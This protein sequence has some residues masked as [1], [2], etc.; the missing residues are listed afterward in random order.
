M[1]F[2]LVLLVTVCDFAA[3]NGFAQRFHSTQWTREDGLPSNT[4]ADIAQTPDGFLWV[5]TAEGLA[6]YDGA[7]FKLFNRRTLPILESDII[8]KLD[9]D[10]AG[11]LWV[12]TLTGGVYYKDANGWHRVAA[13]VDEEW[14]VI[15]LALGA[16]GDVWAGTNIGMA[17]IRPSPKGYVF[18]ADI[19]DRGQPVT[20]LG[21]SAGDSVSYIRRGTKGV[22]EYAAGLAAARDSAMPDAKR[23]SRLWQTRGGIA[24]FDWGSGVHLI[25]RRAPPR[26]IA[27]EKIPD[28]ADVMVDASGTVWLATL[29][30]GLIAVMP[31]GES[32]AMAQRFERLDGVVRDVFQARDGSIWIGTD[33]QG[34]I[35]LRQPEVE[36]FELADG[37]PLGYV[38][39]VAESPDGRIHIATTHGVA[40]YSSV[41][42]AFVWSGKPNL[43][44]EGL[45]FGM[46]A[47]RG[48][49]VSQPSLRLVDV[50]SGEAI[51]I[52]RG[53]LPPNRNILALQT[54][55]DGDVFAATTHGVM[56]IRDGRVHALDPAEVGPMSIALFE[57]APGEIWVGGVDSLRLIERGRLVDHPYAN[58]LRGKWVSGFAHAADAGFWIATYG[59]GA[60]LARGGRTKH[61]HEVIGFPKNN[62]NAMIR[63]RGGFLW[64]LTNSG[65][66]R[67]REEALTARE[68]GDATPVPAKAYGRTHGL[69][70]EET[71]GGQ[72]PAA[73]LAGDG[74][75]WFAT[76]GGVARIGPQAQTAVRAAPRVH[77]D[78]VRADASFERMGNRSLVFAKGTRA[79]EIDVSAPDLI[80]GKSILVRYRI[81]GFDPDWKILHGERTVHLGNLPPGSHILEM[82]ASNDEGRWIGKVESVTLRIA[83]FFHQTLWF[84]ALLIALTAVAVYGFHRV[85]VSVLKSRYAVMEERARIAAELHDGIAQ[86]FSGIAL[87]IEAAL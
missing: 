30:R 67:V 26:R 35:R 8:T 58:A 83:P 77:V 71:S 7:R 49:V 41:T 44:R 65:I 87:Q 1:R 37:K 39:S 51:E 2:A 32:V 25:E 56:A 6:R 69:A 19:V 9:V 31:D 68:E 10:S 18:D 70:Y 13:P 33:K 73:T 3:A 59:D 46:Y 74:S 63:G 53:T 81:R 79:I 61:F 40:E 82:M 47:G 54:G 86:G 85:R 22:R 34:L 29:D 80:D 15:N 5:A 75:L 21:V 72:Q 38:N 50:A 52:D 28:I 66:Y 42:N 48:L 12:A 55:K 62:L 4:I 14:I 36:F 17:R 84:K 64:F 16:D 60:F 24:V 43:L 45:A 57:R 20:F 78:D 76:S 27:F 23:F 11:R